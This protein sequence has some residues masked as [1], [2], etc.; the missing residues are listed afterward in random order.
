M[1]DYIAIKPGMLLL[2]KKNEYTR[3][4]FILITRISKNSIYYTYSL[5]NKIHQ[6]VIPRIAS[7]FFKNEWTSIV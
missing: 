3:Y 1:T 7:G 2:P 5:K 4:R 6:T